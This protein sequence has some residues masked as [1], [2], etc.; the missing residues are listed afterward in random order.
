MIDLIAV[1]TNDGPIF[2]PRVAAHAL[3]SG[4]VFDPITEHVVGGDPRSTNL[5]QNARQLTEAEKAQV[6]NRLR[7]LL[8]PT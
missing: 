8:K 4:G 2:L 6:Q 7:M 3:A 1:D 5:P